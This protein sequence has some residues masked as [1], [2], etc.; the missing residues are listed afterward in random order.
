MDIPIKAAKEIA[1]AY[2]YDQ[3]IIIGR[4]AGRNEHVTTYGKSKVHCDVAAQIGDFLKY[5]VMRW[6]KEDD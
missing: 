5:K 2:D 1:D 3:I 6:N 4:K